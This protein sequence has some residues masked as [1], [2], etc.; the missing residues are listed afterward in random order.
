M[1]FIG[2]LSREWGGLTA[3]VGVVQAA[4]ARLAKKPEIAGALH[5]LAIEVDEPNAPAAK[6][7]KKEATA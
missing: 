3:V 7:K 1:G 4:S 5:A 2:D 6:A